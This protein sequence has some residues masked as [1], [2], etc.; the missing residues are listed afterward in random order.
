M[1]PHGDAGVDA[2]G[3]GGDATGGG[4]DAGGGDGASTTNSSSGGPAD[5]SS[6]DPGSHADA[7]S[8]GGGSGAGTDSGAAD[9]GSGGDSAT[10]CTTVAVSPAEPAHGDGA[11]ANTGVCHPRSVT[12]FSP[13]WIPPLG[14]HAGACDAQ[15]IT[16]FFDDCY[17]SGGSG[18]TCD[19]FVNGPANTACVACLD[20]PN[21]ASKYGALIDFSGIV[22]VN[23]G[24]CV[25]LVEPCN[26][27]CA[28][29]FEAVADCTAASCDPVSS[30]T[31]SSAYSTCETAAQ[32]GTC[33][34]DGFVASGNCMN[35][36]A[37]ASH[38]S[39]ATCFGSQTS[40]FQTLYTA[41]ATFICGQ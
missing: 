18:P 29:A 20:T 41:V 23:L 12:G 5:G 39:Y 28:Q 36:I 30:C 38:P 13:T 14:P 17:G 8:G 35:T 21:T 33:A 25:S 19:A 7:S 32:S 16:T 26:Q 37:D 24:G 22:Y 10:G 31:T 3:S 2:Q 27:S 15:Q 6:A 4:F 11:C 1:T 40:D 9:T 34:C